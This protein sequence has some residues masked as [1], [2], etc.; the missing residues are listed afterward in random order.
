VQPLV[1]RFLLPET[2]DCE[3]PP[4]PFGKRL[5]RDATVTHST[6]Q[7]QCGSPHR[8][9]IHVML[10]SSAGRTQAE[11]SVHDDVAS[12][13]NGV[14]ATFS[15]TARAASPRHAVDSLWQVRGIAAPWQC[16]TAKIGSIQPREHR[17]VSELLHIP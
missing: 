15:R 6:R 14:A 9:V 17:I 5:S 16:S 2:Q 7:P 12:G 8:A 3:R 11:Q 13:P 10:A 4:S 1:R